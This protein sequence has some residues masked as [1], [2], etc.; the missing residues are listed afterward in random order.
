VSVHF[1]TPVSISAL[2]LAADHV[3]VS[4]VPKQPCGPLERP[5]GDIAHELERPDDAN[6]E[7]GFH[8]PPEG[9]QEAEAA[10]RS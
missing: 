4:G 9:S 3:L 5:D 1:I 10:V 2:C 8:E 6:D 7:A